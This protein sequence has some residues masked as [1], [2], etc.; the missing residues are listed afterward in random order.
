M[1]IKVGETRVSVHNSWATNKVS[2]EK[3]SE[4]HRRNKLRRKCN[5][6]SYAMQIT[7]ASLTR[8]C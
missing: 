1:W 6:Q 8:P 4:R 5:L 3:K 2:S 7:L